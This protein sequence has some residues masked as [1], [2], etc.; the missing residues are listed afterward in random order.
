MSEMG[1]GAAL[2]ERAPFWL[3]HQ[4]LLVPKSG[5]RGVTLAVTKKDVGGWHFDTF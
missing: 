2:Q 3:L 1:S 4:I 5:H